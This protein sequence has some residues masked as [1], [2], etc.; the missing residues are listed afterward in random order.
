MRGGASRA[1]AASSTK[2]SRPAES[3]IACVVPLS[4]A[5]REVRRPRKSYPSVST[6]AAAVLPEGDA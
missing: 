6:Q 3:Y 2:R 4:V 1:P 5:W